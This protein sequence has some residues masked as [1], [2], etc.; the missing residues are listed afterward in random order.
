MTRQA[1]ALRGVIGAV[2]TPFTS[3]GSVDEVRLGGEL[4]LLVEHCDA[5]SVLAAEASEYR[6]LSPASRRRTLVAAIERIGRRSLVLAGATAGS[7]SETAELAELAAAHGADFIQVLIPRRTWGGDPSPDELVGWTNALVEA[8]PLPV[9]LYHNPGHGADPS[10]E[11]LIEM[12]AVPG[13]VALKDSSRNIA[14]VL[15]AVEEIHHAGHAAYFATIQP[16]L[17]VLLSGGAG[18]MTPPPATLL[19]AS[20]RD[21]VADGDLRRAT[22]LQRNA[23]TFPVRWSARYGLVPVMKA[24]GNELGYDLGDPAPPFFAVAED[25]RRAIVAS[26]AAW[27]RVT[28]AGTATGRA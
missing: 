22:D 6:A 3:S 2:L 17:S 15:R 9:V 13:V 19:A 26:V 7:L 1:G 27:P 23:A 5:L 24:A 20:I 12:C 10:L 4:D 21:A 8:S 28:A 16:L 14:R 11:T 25:D 18:A